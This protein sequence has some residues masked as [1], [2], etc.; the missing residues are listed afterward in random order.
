VFVAVEGD[1]DGIAV[2]EPDVAVEPVAQLDGAGLT[3]FGLAVVAGSC[4]ELGP[5]GA[6]RRRRRPGSRR[7][8]WRF[9]EAAI[10]VGDAVEGV[11]PALLTRP[12][13]LRRWY[14]T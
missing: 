1:G 14:S 12:R 6:R 4:G 7:W 3:S 13:G 10:G 8:L 11:P 2:G 5:G 9:G